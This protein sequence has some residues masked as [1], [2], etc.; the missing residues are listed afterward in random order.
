M[1]GNQPVYRADT[2]R[3]SGTVFE[4]LRLRAVKVE[5]I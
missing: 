4:V 2:V 3:T 5:A 1:A